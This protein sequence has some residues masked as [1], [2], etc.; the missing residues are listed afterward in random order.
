MSSLMAVMPAE[1][2]LQEIVDG[3]MCALLQTHSVAESKLDPPRI[4]AESIWTGC[5]SIGGAFTG[6]VTV[7]CTRDFVHR[8]AEAMFAGEQVTEEL[9]RDALAELTNVMGG[10][11][12]SL[13][14]ALTDSTCS[15]SLPAVSTGSLD[16]P[17]S[18]LVGELW[19]VS[20]SDRIGV[21]VYRSRSGDMTRR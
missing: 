14:S 3:V 2:D 13:F 12:K 17:G 6:A 11:I 10:N 9:A 18:T 16:I 21:A 4:A 8:I 5:I 19:S 7:K 1:S 15:L 20:N